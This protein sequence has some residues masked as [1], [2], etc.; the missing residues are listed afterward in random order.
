MLLRHNKIINLSLIFLDLLI[1]NI[2]FIVVGYFTSFLWW[3]KNGNNFYSLIFQFNISWVFL[4]YSMRFYDVDFFFEPISRK[5]IRV[6]SNY[7]LIAALIFFSIKKLSYSYGF[8]II[9]IVCFFLAVL[10]L[11]YTFLL[12]RKKYVFLKSDRRK[13][14][15]IGA[16]IMT[17]E[18]INIL[19]RPDSGYE[20]I[21]R[22]SDE[23][24]DPPSFKLGNVQDAIQYALENNIMD[25]FSLV[26]PYQNIH[27]QEIIHVAEINSIR[28]R[29]IPDLKSFFNREICI[30]VEKNIPIIA[31]RKEPLEQ[32]NNQIRKRVFDIVFSS[33]VF[34]FLLWWLMPI[35]AILLKLDSKGPI[36]FVQTRSGKNGKEFKCY[37]FRSM[38]LNQDADLKPT[39]FNDERI[40]RIGKHLRKT[41]IDELP[42]FLN[43]L[44]GDMSVV[45][46]RPHMTKQTE[47][48]SKNVDAYKVRL[49]LKPGITGLAQVSGLRGELSQEKMIERL[50]LDIR[51]LEE[52]GFWHD[53]RIILRTILLMFQGDKN[54]Y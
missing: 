38:I 21:G 33:L 3:Q 41:S 47:D 36:F 1:L 34:I 49:Y 7:T 42:Q 11:R 13:V 17:N 12:L 29:F 23:Q 44:F 54:A 43:V 30:K 15:L 14:I 40:T 8:F 53:V 22:F 26:L 27:I 35:V 9:F 32:L 10:F 50:A 6:V 4:V 20:Y 19:I 18:I 31:F 25:V 45:G 46:P 37:K 24:D 51:Y 52:W 2:I 48:Y 16:G 28:L 39:V 5:T